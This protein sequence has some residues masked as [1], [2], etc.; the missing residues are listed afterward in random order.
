MS[1][2][3]EIYD[4]TLRDG[5]QGEGIN[6]SLGDKLR[7]AERLDQ[8]GV[9]YIEGGWPGSNPKDAAFFR[10]A[11]NR[12]WRQARIH[13]FG[14][15]RRP[16]VAPEDDQN[17][18]I[19][20]ESRAHGVT[21]FGKSWT[22]HVVDILGT[23]LE[24]N[25]AMIGESIA[26]MRTNGYPV[27]YDAEHF[28]D[29]YTA[30]PA[31]A[32]ATLQA[33]A[34]AGAATIVLCDTNGGALPERVAEVVRTV[35]AQVSL[36]VGIHTHNDCELAVANSLAAVRAGAVHVQG[37]FN[38][39]GERC[40][41]ANLCSIIPTLELKLGMP[42]LPAGRLAHLTEAARFVGE[43]A[44]RAL[45]TG[46]PYVG[47]SAFAHKGGVHVSAMRRSPIAYQHID[48]ALVGNSQ[49]TLISELSGRANVLE[50]VERVGAA[51]LDG[52]RAGAVVEQVKALE[53]EGFSFEGAEASVHLLVA[54]TDPAYRAPF[55]LVDFLVVVQRLPSG[56]MTAQA[57]LK[58]NVD[59]T[60][61]H[62]AADGDGP[63]NALDLAARKAL[64][65]HF[66]R[67]A[68]THL[69]DYKVRVLDGHDGTA[70]SVRVLIETGDLQ[71]SWST[72]GSSV[73]IIEASWMA[74]SDS[75]EF[76]ITRA[77]T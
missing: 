77:R 33:A 69:R 1:S 21:L 14:S 47:H 5:T 70:A 22:H 34:R 26:F 73:N 42:C 65:G 37:T 39:Y 62:T 38:G 19:L 74:L 76:A 12:T 41:N 63:V 8:L 9:D 59:G 31:Y 36:P 52:A 2:T 49:R 46:Q 23:T 71:E 35:R 30:D 55:T 57:M 17:L 28:F 20:V 24:E 16:H 72:V 48:P 10:A 45:E 54:R 58:L 4:T 43:V 6:L 18:R 64:V 68:E 13:A 61:V 7:I 56:G 66:P 15:T 44:N 50:L 25:L 29:G 11:A 40:G 53:N 67:L 51:G 60:I 3:L 32:L 75:L 27:I